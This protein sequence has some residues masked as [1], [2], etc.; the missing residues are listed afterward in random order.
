MTMTAPAG[1]SL[2]REKNGAVYLLVIS[3][4][5]MEKEN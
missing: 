1:K 2:G 4:P 5:E 3:D